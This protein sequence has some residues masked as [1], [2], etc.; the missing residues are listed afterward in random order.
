MRDKIMRKPL[1]HGKKFIA[2]SLSLSALL[3]AGCSAETQTNKESSMNDFQNLSLENF[4]KEYKANDD[5]V[6]YFQYKD[7]ITIGF[8]MDSLKEERWKKDKE[9]FIDKAKEMK[10]DVRITEANG[11]E[12]LQISQVEEL[13]AE[14]VNV[15]VIVPVNGEVAS[16]TVE[17]AHNAGI[18][19]ISYDRLI[20]NSD[21]DY[22][23]SFD[24]EK[25]GELQ[26]EAIL[27]EV[28][29]GE[30]SY[31]GGSPSDNN[32]L[33]FRKGAMDSLND[34]I[35]NNEIKILSDDYSKDWK[36][37]EAYNHTKEMLSKHKDEI[38]AVISANDGTA[39]GVIQ[40]L[41]ENGLAGKIPVTGQDA[42]LPALQRIVEGTQ[43]MTVYKPVHLI[44]EKA[45]EIAV[46][47][48]KGNNVSTNGEINNGHKQVASY[49]LTPVSVTKE[50]MLDTVIKDE[51]N[52]YEAIYKNIPKEERPS[53]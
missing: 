51:Y 30:I 1:Q 22:Y 29:Q 3:V 5:K 14:G 24:N 8:A 34:E 20:T 49:L 28:P 23:V 42:D 46:E 37:E 27:K 25:V 44:A 6:D 4:Q 26:A 32:A 19:V 48:A 40:A 10:S 21:L 52:T 47:V 50:N 53:R 7:K 38:D 13:I 35:K 18:K 12:R 31:V 45:V 43:L 16:I 39:G 41:K 36:P 9:V 11:D 17:M 33:L 2:L 15:L